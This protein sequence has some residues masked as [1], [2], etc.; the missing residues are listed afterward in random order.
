MWVFLLK[1]GFQLQ[2]LARFKPKTPKIRIF[3]MNLCGFLLFFLVLL[4]FL[5]DNRF[6]LW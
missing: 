6:E 5:L 4:C 1:F 3:G 2:N